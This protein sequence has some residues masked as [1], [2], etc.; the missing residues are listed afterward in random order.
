MM[1]GLTHPDSGRCAVA[2]ARSVRHIE[3][4]MSGIMCSDE[5]AVVL[6]SLARASNPAFSDACA[7]ELSEGTEALFAI[8]FPLPEEAGIPAARQ[9]GNPWKSVSTSF[10]APSEHGFAS[11]AGVVTHSWATRDPTQ[12]DAIIAR[13]LVSHALAILERERVVQALARAD[14]RAAKLAIEL[15]ASR[16]ARPDGQAALPGYW[17]RHLQV[18]DG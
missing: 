14:D 13:L 12:D 4:V 6:S 1:L 5:P 2:I 10:Q 16:P 8:S 3:G 15:I 18:V 17:H 11:F 9:A 7:I